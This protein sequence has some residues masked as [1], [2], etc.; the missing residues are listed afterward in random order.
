MLQVIF[1]VALVPGSV[2]VDIDAIAV[3][4]VIVPLALKHVAINVPEL[5]LAACLVEPPIPFVAGT[6]RPDLHTI[7]MLHVAKPL[8]LVHSSV[9]EDDFAFILQLM[10]TVRIDSHTLSFIDVSYMTGH[11]TDLISFFH[12]ETA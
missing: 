10:L 2:H 8:P 6:I 1:P 9:L 7:A 12:G 11:Y 5:A 4:F 3:G